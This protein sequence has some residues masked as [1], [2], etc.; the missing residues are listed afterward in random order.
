M[1][2]LQPGG[3]VRREGRRRG[4]GG[5]GE[6]GVVDESA[7]IDFLPIPAQRQHRQR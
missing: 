3:G 1:D 7:G 5:R 4:R 2:T 6:G